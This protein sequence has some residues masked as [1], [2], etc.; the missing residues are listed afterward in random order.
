MPNNNWYK[1][2]CFTTHLYKM[3]YT[4]KRK[5]EAHWLD[6][7]HIRTIARSDISLKDV[8]QKARQFFEAKLTTQTPKQ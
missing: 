4:H 3:Q 1:D 6:G 2:F 8:R 7:N 5:W